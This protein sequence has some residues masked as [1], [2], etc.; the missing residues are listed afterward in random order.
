MPLFLRFMRPLGQFGYI[1]CGMNEGLT[2]LE[3][4]VE[5]LNE[6]S[7][8]QDPPTASASHFKCRCYYL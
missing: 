6:K 4:V 3:S 8:L 7:D 2:D 1:F 5:N